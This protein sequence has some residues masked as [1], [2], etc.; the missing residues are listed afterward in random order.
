[1]PGPPPV[2][3]FDSA[4]RLLPMHPC[5]SSSTARLIAR[6]TL[7]AA[8]DHERHRLVPSGAVAPVAAMLA[9][10]GPAFW[11]KLA[12]HHP[13]AGALLRRLEHTV[14]PGIITHYLARKRWLEN[15]TT[16]AL[17]SGCTQVVILGAG[18]DSLAWRLHRERP[19][20]RFFELDHP[21]TQAAKRAA[22][23]VEPNFTFLAADLSS[24][25]PGEVLCGCPAFSPND[26][27]LFLA[28]GLLM[29]FPEARVAAL[30]RDL[31]GLTLPAA[32]VLFSFMAA[33]P[34]GSISFQGEHAAVGWWLRR[35]SEPFRWGIA[36]ADLPAFLRACGLESQAL[37][38][39]EVL[40]DRILAPLGL[41]GL[42]L[43]R[44]ECLCQCSTLAP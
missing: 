4:L 22:L 19:G 7:L 41:A 36:R 9:A 40:R 21:A 23:R 12:L 38:D 20:V 44:G 31:A 29:Y 35:Q 16:S 2:N 39:H 33:G 3:R 13:G 17:A 43:A 34:D 6:S 42:P 1:M 25:L 10:D 37:A 8:H 5:R 18:F 24:V 15:A 32:T 11:F 28:E 26:P 14:L 30:L 27:T